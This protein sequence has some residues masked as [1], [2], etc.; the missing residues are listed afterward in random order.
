MNSKTLVMTLAAS[1]VL[2]AGNV[3]AG[4]IYKYTDED[5]TVSYVDRPTTDPDREQMAIRSRP[6]DNAAI[7]A[8]TQARVAAANAAAVEQATQKEA[9]GTEKLTRGERRAAAAEKQQQCDMY[10]AQL[11]TI[12]AARRLVREDENGERI[13]LDEDETQAAKDQVRER[14]QQNCS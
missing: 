10:R 7:Q 11:D 8:N 3:L 4:E 14:I 1:S 6:T 12:A 13:Y 5:G 2:L 9:A